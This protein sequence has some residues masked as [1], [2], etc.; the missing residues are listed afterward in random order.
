METLLTILECYAEDE[1]YFAQEYEIEQ[2]EKL[3]NKEHLSAL[4]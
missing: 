4:R 1:L 3:I 2:I